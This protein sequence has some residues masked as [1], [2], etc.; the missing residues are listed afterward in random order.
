MPVCRGVSPHRAITG[1]KV[2]RAKL[3]GAWAYRGR[4]REREE[5]GEEGHIGAV[6]IHLI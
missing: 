3:T 1:I 4:E 2:R 6:C 5:Q